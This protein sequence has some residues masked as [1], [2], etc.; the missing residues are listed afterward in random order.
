M[1]EGEYGTGRLWWMKTMVK[2]D[3]RGDISSDNIFDI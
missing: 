2:E 1:M 3:Y